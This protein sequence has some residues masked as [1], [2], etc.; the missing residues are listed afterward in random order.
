MPNA[1][2]K[3]IVVVSDL[4][5]SLQL[6]ADVA[7]AGPV[8]RFEVDAATVRVGMGWPTIDG[9]VRGATIG[10]APGL[11]ELVEIPPPLVGQVQPG[12]AI[13]SFSLRDVEGAAAAATGAGH[14]VRGPAELIIGG[15]HISTLAQATGAD[16]HL[17]IARYT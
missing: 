13:L 14:E 2:A 4:D 9:T 3:V 15:R 7:G 8:D 6:I 10:Q 16:L 5:A 12:S 11:I 1:I 17:E